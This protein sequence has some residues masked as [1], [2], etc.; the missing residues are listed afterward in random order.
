[1]KKNP[2]QTDTQSQDSSHD[3]KVRR[4][5]GRLTYAASAR[6]VKSIKEFKEKERAK[7]NQ[8]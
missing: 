4:E 3:K 7:N 5:E 2:Q 8:R 1:M 6:F